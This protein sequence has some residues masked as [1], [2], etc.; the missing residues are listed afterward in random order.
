M[1][2][3]DHLE[4]AAIGTAALAPN[5]VESST[6]HVISRDRDEDRRFAPLTRINQA[7]GFRA[8]AIG[9]ERLRFQRSAALTPVR[10]AAPERRA[11]LE[12]TAAARHQGR[13]R[14]RSKGNPASVLQVF[15]ASF[16]DPARR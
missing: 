2:T 3:Q 14:T 11:I 12:R 13:A 15:Q 10:Q 16:V 1:P 7:A 5:S 8:L 6:L 4:P 9:R